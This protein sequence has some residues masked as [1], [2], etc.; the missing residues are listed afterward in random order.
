MEF[1][2][3]GPCS[4][5]EAEPV[6]VSRGYG[7]DHIVLIVALFVDSGVVYVVVVRELL[8]YGISKPRYIVSFPVDGNHP[9]TRGLL[10]TDP[11]KS[12]VVEREDKAVTAS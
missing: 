1:T 8:I 12:G 2:E 9:P 3:P 6:P 4:H 10:P 7:L 11:T 5:S